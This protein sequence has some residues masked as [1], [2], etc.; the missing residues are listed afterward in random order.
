MSLCYFIK[1]RSRVFNSIKII[2]FLLTAV[3]RLNIKQLSASH[4]GYTYIQLGSL[5]RFT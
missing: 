3:Q 5:N 1:N 2:L 4:G